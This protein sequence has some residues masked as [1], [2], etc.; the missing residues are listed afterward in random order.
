M[1]ITTDEFEQ[2]EQWLLEQLSKGARR[3]TPLVVQG[4]EAGL[5]PAAIYEVIRQKDKFKITKWKKNT[6]WEIVEND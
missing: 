5:N 4:V 2:A 1:A 3:P 6:W